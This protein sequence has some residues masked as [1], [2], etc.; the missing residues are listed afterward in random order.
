[1]F[2]CLDE[3]QKKIIY[4]IRKNEKELLTAITASYQ[5]NRKVS[6]KH[7]AGNSHGRF[8]VAGDGNGDEK[9]PCHYSTLPKWGGGQVIGS[10]TKSLF[11]SLDFPGHK[12]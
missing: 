3:G 1:M 11:R 8:D 10:S 9:L 2:F 12:N 5:T 7:T 4:K 6:G